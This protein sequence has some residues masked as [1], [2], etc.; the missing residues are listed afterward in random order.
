MLR[1]LAAA[2]FFLLSGSLV[3]DARAEDSSM[4]HLLNV[5]GHG[6]VRQRPDPAVVTAGVISQADTAGAALAANT[7]AMQS[8]MKTLKDAG[9]A[10][11]DIQTSNFAVQPR[12]DCNEGQHPKFLGY[13]VQ[14]TVTVSLRDLGKLGAV[15]DRL[16]KSG[17]NQING[18]SF[19]LADPAAALDEARKLAVADAKRKAD[20]YAVAGG[21]TLGPVVSLVEGGRSQPPVPMRASMAKAGYSAD[22]PVAAGEQIVAVDITMSWSLK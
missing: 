21:L 5:G 2:S 11:K 13:D 4:Q 20:I 17:A 15:L 18:I 8:V 7:S 12:Y 22:V 9:V 6:E 10:D 16:V 14:N 19:D 1:R 3:I